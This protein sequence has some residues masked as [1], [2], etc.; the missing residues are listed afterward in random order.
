MLDFDYG[1]FC[2]RLAAQGR[3]R[4]LRG[5]GPARG[6]SNVMQ[7]SAARVTIA[8]GSL[9]CIHTDGRWQR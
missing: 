6:I 2:D 3:R 1:R 8:G 7:A 5:F 4:R 9:L